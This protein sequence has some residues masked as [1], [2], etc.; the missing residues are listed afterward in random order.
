MIPDGSCFSFG[1][2]PIYEALAP[3]LKRK[4]H[5]GIHTPFFTDPLMDLVKSGAVTNRKKKFFR[6]KCLATY[7]FGTQELMLWLD[8]NPMMEFQPLDVVLD[9]K[10]IGLNDRFIAILPARKADLTGDIALHVGKGNVT[11]SPGAIQEFAAG[12]A[13]SANGKVLFALPSRNLKGLSNIVLSVSDL[14]HQFSN[15]E[16][17]DL[18]VTEYGVAYLT[19]RTVRERALALIDIAH[20]GDREKIFDQA[21]QAK[22]LYSDQIYYV[23][24]EHLYPDHLS[25]IHTFKDNLTVR[26]RAIKSSDEDEMRRLFY[27]FSDQAVY[28]RYFSPIKT[29]PHPKM[30]EYVNIDYNRIMSIVGVVD[31]P[32][33]EKII[34]EARYVRRKDTAYADTAFIVDEDYQGKGIAS[35][36]FD[37]LTRIAKD[38]G[39][40]GF[41]ADVLVDNKAML[42]VYEKA[43]FPMKAQIAGGVYELTIPFAE[44]GSTDME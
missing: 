27:R 2:G 37:M 9:P 22:L 10:N 13:M 4:R 21:K 8:R 20:P 14:P 17:L 36:L 23:D 26:L 41:T 6:G 43:P 34:A 31:A 32:G 12:A 19:G 16:S 15:R 35:F 1:I 5:L 29:M 39:I 33:A 3:Q 7:T 28:Y 25:C 38:N 44:S 42:R 18:I 40:E 24:S 30:Q 11:A